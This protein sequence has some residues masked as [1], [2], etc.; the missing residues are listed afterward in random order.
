VTVIILAMLYHVGIKYLPKIQGKAGTTPRARKA[1][2]L[3][4]GQ[5]FNMTAADGEVI[6]LTVGPSSDDIFV[7]ASSTSTTPATPR[8]GGGDDTKTKKRRSRKKKK[9]QSAI[10]DSFEDGEVLDTTSRDQ[11]SERMSNGNGEASNRVQPDDGE[12]EEY[13]PR[14]CLQENVGN[15]A[16]MNTQYLSSPGAG[17]STLFY[18]DVTPA[19]LPV[20]VAPTVPGQNPV[21]HI[22]PYGGVMKLLLPAHVEVLPTGEGGI[23]P[24]EILPPSDSESDG[25]AI[26]YLDYDDRKVGLLGVSDSAQLTVTG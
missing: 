3:V 11:S 26:E 8:S 6:D 14:P 9:K 13:I 24:V 23:I 4:E 10:A 12:L 2:Y 5:V 19:E 25:D 22:I 17:P 21:T 1:V 16:D 20:A 15:T 7:L 18:E